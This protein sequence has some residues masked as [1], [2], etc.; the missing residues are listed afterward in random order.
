MRTQKENY[1]LMKS[2]PSCYSIDDLKRDGTEMWDGTRN[3]QVRNMM[4]DDMKIGDMALFYHSNA[5]EI[6]CV[7]VM[8]VVTEAYPDPTQFDP[9]S[10]HP[11]PKS[12]KENPTWLC[13]DVK[14]V[15]KLP[16]TVTLHELKA[17][18]F[19]DDMVVTQKGSR[20]SVQPVKKKHFEKIVKL[21]T[22]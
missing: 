14:F 7:G 9:K 21:A 1:W 13:V 16:R 20:L 18:H 19:F 22:A 5:A 6:G 12:K 10:D 15:K 8:K 17:D 11:D 4:R 3:Y 2:E